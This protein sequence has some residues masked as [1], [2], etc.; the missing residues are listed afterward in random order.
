MQHENV[1]V[2]SALLPPFAIGRASSVAFHLNGEDLTTQVSSQLGSR[3]ESQ[4]TAAEL[5]PFKERLSPFPQPRTV[6]AIRAGEAG[7]PRP[8]STRPWPQIQCLL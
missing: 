1:H 5:Q 3:A 2:T 4:G 8:A 6:P 7:C